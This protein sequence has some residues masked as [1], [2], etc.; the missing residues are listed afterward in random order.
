VGDC[1]GEKLEDFVIET[2]DEEELTPKAED[3]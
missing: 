3:N 2:S 1:R